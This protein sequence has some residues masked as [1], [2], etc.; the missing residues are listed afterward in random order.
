M[1]RRDACV[2]SLHLGGHRSPLAELHHAL[3]AFAYEALQLH[4]R[5]ML[6]A[7][8]FSREEID[9]FLAVKK[10]EMQMR[11]GGVTGLAHESDHIPSINLCAFT[12]AAR[13]ARE[14]SRAR[15]VASR[16]AHFHKI[17]VSWPPSA[18]GYL[19]AANGNHRR[20]R[21]RGIVDGLV[22]AQDPGNWMPA[23]QAI[24]RGYSRKA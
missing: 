11:A 20:A 9:L 21:G 2:F 1:S 24:G 18:E 5:K 23:R 4:A 8:Y 6:A 19:A 16:M 7:G 13:N 15:R 3:L 22:R 17:A 10:L 12:D 14:M